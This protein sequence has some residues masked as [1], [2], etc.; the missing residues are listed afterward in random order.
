MCC[1][2]TVT[3]HGLLVMLVLLIICNLEGKNALD[4]FKETVKR[5]LTFGMALPTLTAT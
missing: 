5:G 1:Q 3:A 2:L 4:V